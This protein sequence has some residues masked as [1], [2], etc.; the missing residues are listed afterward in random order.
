[1][2]RMSKIEDIIS[3]WHDKTPHLPATVRQWLADNSWWVAL[4]IAILGAIVIFF[5]LIPL[6]LLGAVLSGLA[7]VLGAVAGGLLLLIAIIWMLVAIVSIILLAVAVGPLKR[8]QKRGWNLLF[9]AL[10]INV[11]VIVLKLLIDFEPASFMLG[12]LMAALAGYLLFEM[13]D[14]FTPTAARPI[15]LKPQQ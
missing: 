13:K 6:L 8:H 5:I 12:L 2:E 7:G 14:H 11:T 1:M 15:E 9:F 3:E 10:L 4:A